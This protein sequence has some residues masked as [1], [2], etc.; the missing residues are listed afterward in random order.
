MSLG[1]VIALVL[2]VLVAMAA[3]MTA[4]WAWQRAVDNAGWTDVFW[5]FGT[6]ATCALAALA[7]IGGAP[8]PSWRQFMVAA[9]VAIWASRLGR[10]IAGRVRGRP[11][12]TRYAG[13]RT[14]WGRSFQGRMLGLSIIQA[15]ASAVLSLSVLMAARNPAPELRPA[16]MVGAAILVIA[17]V[18]ESFADAQMKHFKA[19]RHEQSAVCDTGL[20]S[21]S[22]HPNYFFEAF[23]WLAYP[24]IAVGTSRPWSWLSLLAPVTMFLLLCFGSGVPPLEAAMVRSKGEAYRRYQRRV[25]ALLPLPPRKRNARE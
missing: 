24:V 10:Y 4:S 5:T 6:G 22:R 1:T 14:E 9:L 23:G 19:S 2:D 12:D 7:P 13:L 11:E 16:D 15:P 8:G 25:S 20:W 17:I 18:G 3:V 21:W